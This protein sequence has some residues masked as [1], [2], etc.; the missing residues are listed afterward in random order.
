MRVSRYRRRVAFCDARRTASTTRD[1]A[2]RLPNI[3]ISPYVSFPRVS[4]RLHFFYPFLLLSMSFSIPCY[5]CRLTINSV[6]ILE[7]SGEILIISEET[8]IANAIRIEARQRWYGSFKRPFQRATLKKWR[9][10]PAGVVRL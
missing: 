1:G 8:G 9:S 2:S 4:S 10:R 6:T 5:M 7:F 3:R